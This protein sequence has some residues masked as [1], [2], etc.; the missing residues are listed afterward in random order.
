MPFVHRSNKSG[1]VLRS[2]GSRRQTLWIAQSVIETTLASAESELLVSLLDS[3]GLALRPF[4]IVRTVGAL[5][6]RSDQTSV[7]ESYQA[8]F[9]AA[10]VSDQA[11]AVGITAVPAPATDQGS[12]LFF[13]FQ[14][15]MGHLEV[16]SDIGRYISAQTVSFDSRAMRKVN[17]DEQVVFVAQNSAVS[18]G[19]II[20]SSLRMLLKLH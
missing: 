3:V 13:L 17:E 7:A 4:T 1:T 5:M 11:A 8:A 9:A 6:L 16:T 2:G 15:M 19:S 12:D 18:S 10:V 20:T 14:Q